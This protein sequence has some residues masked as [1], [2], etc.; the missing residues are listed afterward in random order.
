MI[1][2]FVDSIVEE[3]IAIV[4]INRPPVN[5]LSSDV[6]GE[7]YEVFYRLS[8]DENVKAVV[9]TGHGQKAFAAGA[10]IKEFV[11]LNQ[12][13][14]PLYTNRNNFVRE[15]IRTFPKP[16]ICAINGLAYGAGLVL[17]L[18]CD[19]RIAAQEAKFNMGEI[20]MG[21]IGG[22]QALGRMLQSGIA[23]KMVYTGQPI[24][25]EDAQLAGIVDEITNAE[26]LLERAKEIAV[27]ISKKPPMAIKFAKE[28]ML[29]T[30]TNSVA[31]SMDHENA[32][33]KVLWASSDKNE[34]VN[35]FLEK[36]EGKF[37]GK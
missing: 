18:L 29:M 17:A 28:C 8:K 34:A 35:A 14:G 3:S 33:L 21:I 23:R 1:L 25:A 26:T 16:I 22:T 9:L 7:I 27:Q 13:T 11:K 4:T 37:E 30:Y 20:N 2:E 12:T 36:R 32:A 15:Y 6:N 5:A 19:I 31:E 10:D 24:T